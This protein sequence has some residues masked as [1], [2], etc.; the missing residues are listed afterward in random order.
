M[1]IPAWGTPEASLIWLIPTLIS[2]LVT[3]KTN[4]KLTCFNKALPEDAN[5]NRF[6]VTPTVV[7]VLQNHAPQVYCYLSSSGKV[8]FI[9]I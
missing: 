4:I 9:R 8:V 5:G 2:A 3:H 1:E 6:I 7:P